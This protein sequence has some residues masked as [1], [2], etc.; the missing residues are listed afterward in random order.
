MSRLPQRLG[1]AGYRALRPAL[2]RLGGG[3]PEVAHHATMAALHRVAGNPCA[4]AALRT[5]SSTPAAPVTVGGITFPGRVGMAAGMDKYAT[6]VRAWAPLGFSHIELGTVTGQAQPGN[7]QPR[8]F[9]APQSR[10][11]INRMGFNN[12]GAV[13]MADALRRQGIYR[14]EGYAGI[15]VGISLGKTK[16]VDL[17]RAVADY[18]FSFARLHW[19]AD[20]IAVNVSSPNT[21]GLR[22]LQE[23][24]ALRELLGALTAAARTLADPMPIFVKIAPDLSFADLDDV[25]TVCADTGVSALIATNTTLSREGL[26]GADTALAGEAGGLSGAPLT[27]RAREVVGYLC[28]HSGLPV[29][30]VGGIMSGADARALLDLGAAMVQVY[31][32]FIYAGPRLVRQI[33]ELPGEMT[34]SMHSTA[35][36]S[37]QRGNGRAADTTTTS[38]RRSSDVSPAKG[39]R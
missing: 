26:V 4:R 5:L 17:D 16:V 10:A 13:A 37:S 2:F 34:E 19:H 25:L 32:G 8:L 11:L 3:D 35:D 31:T 30:G 18:L 14:G 15:P 22:S 7:P 20:Y 39:T 24:A 9:R 38:I 27:A 28:A 36:P 33:N 6:A 29:I 23:G 21:P 12:P 1:E